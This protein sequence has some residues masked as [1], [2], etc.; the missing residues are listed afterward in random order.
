MDFNER[1]AAGTCIECK[2]PVTGDGTTWG[3]RLCGAHLKKHDV[4][5]NVSVGEDGGSHLNV[6]LSDRQ[7]CPV[8]AQHGMCEC[9]DCG[10][11]GRNFGFSDVGT[12]V[13]VLEDMSPEEEQVWSK[14]FDQ[15][16]DRHTLHNQVEDAF[17]H[18]SN[19]K[20]SFSERYANQQV[21]PY[22]PE[23]DEQAAGHF[24]SH[25]HTHFLGRLMS[26]KPSTLMGLAKVLGPGGLVRM[27]EE[28]HL[29]DQRHIHQTNE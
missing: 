8:C 11:G 21:V 9:G 28:L 3:N 10:D 5:D 20:M 24:L 1:Y 14:A 15:A 13:R 27:H 4:M 19:K 25:P 23:D 7:H 6:C 22:N 26:Q 29:S 18:E 2:K 17:K 16:S 12:G